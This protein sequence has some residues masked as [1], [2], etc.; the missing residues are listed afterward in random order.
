[1]AFAPNSTEAL[2]CVINGIV[3]AGDRVVT[4]VLEHNSVLRPLNRLAA[5]R[6][7]SVAHAGCDALGRP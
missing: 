5:E 6:G 7:V 1:M 4:T 2:N 3:G